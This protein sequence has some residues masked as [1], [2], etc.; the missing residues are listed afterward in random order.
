MRTA[1]DQFTRLVEHGPAAVIEHRHVHAQQ[2]ALQFAAPDR[3]QRIAAEKAAADVGA[4]GDRRNL[5]RLLPV[6][7]QIVEGLR[8]Q[9]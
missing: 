5:Q 1:T 2:C 8:Q 9:R 6:L 4:T 7:V 3:Q